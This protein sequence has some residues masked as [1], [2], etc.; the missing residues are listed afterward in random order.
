MTV[1]T[2]MRMDNTTSANVIGTA[3]AANGVLYVATKSKL[4]ALAAE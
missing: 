3:V 2:V 1:I 4:Y